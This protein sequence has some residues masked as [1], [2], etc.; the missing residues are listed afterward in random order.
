MKL[1]KPSRHRSPPRH[2]PG[3]VLNGV[4][5][6]LAEAPA[7]RRACTFGVLVR[8]L[9]MRCGVVREPLGRHVGCRQHPPSDSSRVG[10]RNSSSGRRRACRPQ[11]RRWRTDR[12]HCASAVGTASHRKDHSQHAPAVTAEGRPREHPRTS[13]IERPANTANTLRG[14]TGPA[15]THCRGGSITGL[16]TE[17]GQL[18]SSDEPTTAVHGFS[19]ARS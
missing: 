10:S 6:D 2:Y 16:S 4:G 14:L 15:A 7:F 11:N 18:Q 1:T 19:P 8:C 3:V 12:R 13:L 17:S 9:R 5:P